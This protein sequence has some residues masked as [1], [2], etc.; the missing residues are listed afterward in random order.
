M[1]QYHNLLLVS[2]TTRCFIW[3]FGDNKSGA[4]KVKCVAYCHKLSYVIRELF[5]QKNIVT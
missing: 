5:C 4:L 3:Y 2:K 1:Y